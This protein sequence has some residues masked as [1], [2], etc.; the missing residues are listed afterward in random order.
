MSFWRVSV[1]I[2][3]P[4]DSPA[5]QCC[6]V[7]VVSSQGGNHLISVGGFIVTLKGGWRRKFWNHSSVS[8][9]NSNPSF[10]AFFFFAE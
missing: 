4:G 1:S 2:L 5:L 6:S 10:A 8:E 3:F 7:P 9:L